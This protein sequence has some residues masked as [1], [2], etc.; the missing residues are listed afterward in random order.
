MSFWDHLKK[1][2]AGVRRKGLGLWLQL[3][4]ERFM[5]LFWANLLWAG[6][7][8]PFFIF[9][10]FLVQTGD[11]L[12][13]AA[14]F[15]FWVLAGP[16]NTYLVFVG[17]RVVCGRPVW[18]WQDCKA[19]LRDCGLRSMGLAAVEG[20]LWG[21]LFWAARLVLAVQGG[22]GPFYAA[23]FLCDAFLLTGAAFLGRQQLALVQLPFAAQLKNAF[24]LI[25]AGRL[26]SFAAVSFLLACL[27]ASL[28]LGR[29]IVFVM[30]T[31]LPA[32]AVMTGCLIFYP[33]FQAFFP[34]EDVGNA[35][36]AEDE[37]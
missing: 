17:M 31:G 25:F 34:Q 36:A 2:P 5:K 29:W 27:G 23:V 30:L 16:A 9:L 8:L 6:W 11:T 3:L 35:S 32:V 22:L 7:L 26:R 20:V 14:A 37:E 10:F 13:L 21:A 28:L 18:V 24:L 4:E 15:L 19:L 1:V 33:V 12:S